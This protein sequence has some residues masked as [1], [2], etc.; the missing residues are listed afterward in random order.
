VVE[1]VGLS[2]EKNGLFDGHGTA[3]RD[4]LLEVLVQAQRRYG[5][6]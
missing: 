2:R 3:K 6:C 5:C 4:R 1:G